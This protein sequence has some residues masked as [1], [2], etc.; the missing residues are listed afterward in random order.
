MAFI[1]IVNYIDSYIK[2]LITFLIKILNDLN[3]DILLL[4][5]VQLNK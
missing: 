1:Y 3:I 4:P 2:I 5:L